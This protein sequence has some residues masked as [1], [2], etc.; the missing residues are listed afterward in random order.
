MAANG[1][2]VFGAV[3]SLGNNLI[4]QTDGSTGWLTL[5]QLSDI[6]GTN[7]NPEESRPGPQRP[8]E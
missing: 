4:G 5:G 6:T 1:P 3:L 2:D 8:D 7:A